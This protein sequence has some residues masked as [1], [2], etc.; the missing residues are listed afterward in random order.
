MKRTFFEI[1]S[2]FWKAPQIIL[3]IDLYTK[4]R[5]IILRK[6]ILNRERE[7]RKARDFV[8]YEEL[9]RLRE[10]AEEPESEA[11]N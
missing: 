8:Y 9:L 1:K 4:Q 2:Q 7:F 10:E 3:W 5:E 11:E 6:K